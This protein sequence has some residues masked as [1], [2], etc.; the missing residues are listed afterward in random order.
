MFLRLIH[1]FYI[2]KTYFRELPKDL[3]VEVVES[4]EEYK[5]LCLI[6]KIIKN[7]RSL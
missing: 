2:I 7:E 3:Q 5:N 4:F 6:N 1:C